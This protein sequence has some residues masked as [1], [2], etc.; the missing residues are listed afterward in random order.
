MSQSFNKYKCFIELKQGSFVLFARIGS[1][2]PV[3]VLRL[4]HNKYTGFN[5]SIYC[6]DYV[7]LF[8]TKAMLLLY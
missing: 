1:G 8:A 7:Q 4:F 5:W 3:R 6:W 2:D